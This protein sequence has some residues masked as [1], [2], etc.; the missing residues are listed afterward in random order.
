MAYV[1]VF[2]SN[3]NNS[4]VVRKKGVCYN[5]S[6]RLSESSKNDERLDMKRKIAKTVFISLLVALLV[7]GCSSSGDAFLSGNDYVKDIKFDNGSLSYGGIR[8]GMSQDEVIHYLEENK[9]AYSLSGKNEESGFYEQ[10]V[11]D[12]PGSYI[13][14]EESGY[15]VSA[16]MQAGVVEIPS[17]CQT[18]RD[19]ANFYADVLAD[20]CDELTTSLGNP[21]FTTHFGYESTYYWFIGKDGKVVSNIAM[22]DEG[23]EEFKNM[24]C[25]AI[26]VSGAKE[27]YSMLPEKIYGELAKTL[28][29]T[30]P[31]TFSEK[32]YIN[33]SVA[34]GKLIMSELE[35]FF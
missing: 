3:F 10:I 5:V 14:F 13:T 31:Y 4:F 6:R 17:S 9:I 27:Q 29:T 20:I 16:V 1:N 25:F 32:E 19:K 24:S 2:S 8:V 22:S 11:P 33:V 18:N 26:V 7:C 15:T 12:S 23:I 28:F 35:V 21:M 34:D 30:D